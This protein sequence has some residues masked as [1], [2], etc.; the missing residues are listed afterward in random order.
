MNSLQIPEVKDKK[1][2]NKINIRKLKD[3]KVLQKK[4]I[5]CISQL[6]NED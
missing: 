3:R 6:M 2:N 5:D 4:G 1:K